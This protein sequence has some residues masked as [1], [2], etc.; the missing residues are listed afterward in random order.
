MSTYWLW[1]A[2]D[3]EARRG[4][5]QLVVRQVTIKRGLIYAANGKTILAANRT[6]R[7]QG[8]T[9]STGSSTQTATW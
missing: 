9:W 2:P 3:L 5:P 8:R 1:K 7:V 6:K 4:N